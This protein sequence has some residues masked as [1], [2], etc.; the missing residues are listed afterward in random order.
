MEH[1]FY[2]FLMAFTRDTT[3][4]EEYLINKFGKDNLI[5]LLK[6]MKQLDNLMCSE[7]KGMGEVDSYGRADEADE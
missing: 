4:G 2:G 6:M 1:N 3:P 5:M 7:I